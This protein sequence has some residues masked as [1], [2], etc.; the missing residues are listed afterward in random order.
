VQTHSL[1]P[2][3]YRPLQVYDHVPAVALAP[4]NLRILIVN[5]DMRSADSLKRTLHDLGYFMTLTAYSARRAL[6]AAVDFSPAVVL[7]DLELPDMTGYQLAQK[8]HSHSR[9]YVRQL[10][11]LAIAER[12]VLGDLDRTRA[13]G[14]IGCLTKPVLPMVLN[15]ILRKLQ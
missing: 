10:P 8:L 6:V 2:T 5:E 3:R 13:A 9:R 4:A 7:L 14:F 12:A 1:A 15:D 11:L